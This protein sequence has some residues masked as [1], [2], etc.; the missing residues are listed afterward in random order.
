MALVRHDSREVQFK[1]VYCGPAGGGKTTTLRYIHRRLDSRLRGDLMSISTEQDRTLHFD[2]LPIHATEIA[3][4]K[5]RF[6]LYTVPGQA[7]L[8]EARQNVLAG[9]DGVVFVADSAP[10][11]IE[12]NRAAREDLDGA[13]RRHRLD[14]NVFPVV[15]QYNKRDLR[16]AVRPEIL[17]ELLGVRTPSFLCCALSGYQVFASLDHLTKAVLSGFHLANRERP[18]PSGKASP[19]KVRIAVG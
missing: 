6:Q 18:R 7:V 3:G 2:Y 15:Y 13:L 4:Y 14:P 10:D 9:A 19:G 8:R 11:R 5:T 16:G 17:D 1:I 12:A